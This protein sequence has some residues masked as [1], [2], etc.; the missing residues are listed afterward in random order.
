MSR[1]LQTVWLASFPKSGNTW[2]RLLLA[3][4]LH[5]K[6]GPVDIND[7]PLP[8][9]GLVNR[10]TIEEHTLI[11]SSLLLRHEVERLRPGWTRTLLAQASGPVFI[12]THDSL[13]LNAAGEPVIGRHPSMRALYV[14]R[15]PRDVSV[16]LAHHFGC[17]IDT[18]V[19][20]VTSESAVPYAEPGRFTNRFDSYLGNWGD[21]V[22]GWLDQHDMPVHVLRY[23]DMLE[24][25]VAVLQSVI[26]FLGLEASRP[27]LEHAVHCS[28]FDQLQRQEQT[29][30]FRERSRKATAPFFRS[31]RAGA[32][33][34]VLS[35]AQEQKIV[36]VH[37]LVMTRLGY[38]DPG[39]SH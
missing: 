22:R 12:K 10:S 33:S 18:A 2:L 11:D 29:T 34:Q 6:T 36:A 1:E 13:H 27:A 37:R 21:H 15:D 7:L 35:T 3:N 28:S 14:V 23:E 32:W 17:S 26:E 38:L 39:D 20:I 24:Q 16:S 9:P 31:G 19:E 30:G 25:P 4:L 8:G 5:G